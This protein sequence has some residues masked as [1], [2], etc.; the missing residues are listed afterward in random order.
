MCQTS[1]CETTQQNFLSDVQQSV[2]QPPLPPE[3][4]LCCCEGEHCA[5]THRCATETCRHS[6][7]WTLGNSSQ[8]KVTVSKWTFSSKKIRDAPSRIVFH[9]P[10]NNRC[11]DVFEQG[12]VCNCVCEVAY[13]YF[14]ISIL[15]RDC[16]HFFA[17]KSFFEAG[18]V[19]VHQK[20]Y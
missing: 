10:P 13:M 20:F 7:R 17:R 18:H 9:P 6:R 16:S 8:L 3:Q 12:N 4:L 11:Q 15:R 19:C 1:G 2:C 14:Y 5:E